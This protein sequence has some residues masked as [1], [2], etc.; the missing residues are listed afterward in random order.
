MTEIKSENLSKIFEMIENGTNP[1]EILVMFPQE[2]KEIQE[3]ISL[4]SSLK[5]ESDRIEAPKE[6][7]QEILE[8]NRVLNRASGRASVQE[9]FNK[10][11]NNLNFM[12]QKLKYSISALGIIALLAVGI[13]VFKSNDNGSGIASNQ[14]TTIGETKFATITPIIG[15]KEVDASV[16]EA[17]DE[18]LNENDLDSELAD[19]ELALADE[20]ELDQINNLVNENEL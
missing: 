9:I 15:N 20:T 17:L 2:R 13:I 14:K 11:I 5:S 19:V 6:I 10:I 3:M 8:K 1:E 7:L 18:V 16:N 12:N 4:I